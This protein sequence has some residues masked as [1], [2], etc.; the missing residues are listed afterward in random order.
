MSD[1]NAPGLWSG[2]LW[3][4]VALSILL[5]VTYFLWL[6]IEEPSPFLFWL[7]ISISI[8]HQAFVWLA[9]RVELNSKATSKTIGLKVYLILFFVF[10]IG[11]LV[12]FLLLG[13]VDFQS[14]GFENP[15]KSILSVAL[16]I[17]AIYTMHSV[18]KFFGFVRAA[19]A[20]H[21]NSKYRDMPLVKKG[22]FRYSNNGMYMF[23]FLIFWGLAFAFD[24]KAA[25]LAAAFTQSYIWVHYFVTE[26]PDMEYLYRSNN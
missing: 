5:A 20:D 19:G 14:L 25:L 22:I 15:T 16:L 7:T 1:E 21:F 11:R 2:Q 26:K 24:S 23:G 10:L 12:S 3:H 17:P 9:W 4:F 13:W 6:A 18:K 8:M